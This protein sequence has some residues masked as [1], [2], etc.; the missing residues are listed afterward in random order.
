M[1]GPRIAPKR[2]PLTSVSGRKAENRMMSS[3]E[4]PEKTVRYAHRF[5]NHVPLTDPSV[6]RIQSNE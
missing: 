5:Q 2:T 6:Q 3:I 1:Y 4:G